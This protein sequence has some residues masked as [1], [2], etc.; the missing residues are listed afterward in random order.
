MGTIQLLKNKNYVPRDV[1]AANCFEVIL[2]VV[3]LSL[4]LVYISL[5]I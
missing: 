4:L 1:D 2:L 5:N 3:I